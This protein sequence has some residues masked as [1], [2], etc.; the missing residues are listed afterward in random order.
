MLLV[1]HILRLYTN[2]EAEHFLPRR[3]QFCAMKRQELDKCDVPKS[4]QL[5][6]SLFNRTKQG[7]PQTGLNGRT[8]TL[9]RTFFR[10]KS[11]HQQLLN[12]HPHQPHTKQV[13]RAPVISNYELLTRP[14]NDRTRAVALYRLDQII[15]IQRKRK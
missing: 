4:E 8:N 11:K 14:V 9:L 7:Q 5:R 1:L 12:R 6:G 3:I 2:T 15:I 10:K 13:F